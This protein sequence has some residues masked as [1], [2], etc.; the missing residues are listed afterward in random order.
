MHTMSPRSQEV[1]ERTPVEAQAYIRALAARVAALEATAQPLLERLRMASHNSSQPPSRAPPATR[2]PPQRRPP[3]GRK[4]GGQPGHQGQTRAWVPLEDVEAVLPI[5]PPYGSRCQHP[6]HGEEGQPQRHQVPELPPVQPVV[7]EYPWPSRLC[8]ACGATTR[9]PRPRGVPTGGFGT[10]VQAIVT[11]CTGAYHLPKRTPQDVRE[12]LFGMVMRLGTITPLEQATVQ[13]MATPVAEAR[14]Y[15]RTQPVAYWDETG[16]R[17][18]H[19]R[20]WLWGAVTAWG[21]VFVVR[22]SRGARGGQELLGERF[23]GMLVT[24]RWS[25]YNWYPT[26]GR[27]VCGAHLWRDIEAMIERGGRSQEIGEGLREQARQM[28]HHWHGVCDGTL[29]HARFRVLRRPRQ[30]Q[31]ARL[32]KAGQTCGVSKTAAVCREVS[33]LYE[34]LWTC[35]RVAGVEPTNH[36]AER[37]IRPGVLWRTGSFGTQSAQGARFV[38]VMRTVGATLKQQPRHVLTYLTYVYQAAPTGA[39]APSLLLRLPPP[40]HSCRL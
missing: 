13:A 12:D 33:K 7:T 40:M 32:L 5:K 38:E 19:T 26:R 18:G 8:P 2:R 4:S 16:W 10:H 1:W 30:C 37:A 23:C 20:A 3:S 24:D 17:A 39:P 29:T 36:T 9:A 34:A 22:L 28:F 14:T 31:G 27:Q 25:A 35:V 15:V 11:L 21:T 6:L